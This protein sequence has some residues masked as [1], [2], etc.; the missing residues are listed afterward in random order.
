LLR[1]IHARTG[2]R[3]CDLVCSN[4]EAAVVGV[5]GACDERCNAC[6]RA[7]RGRTRSR[8]GCARARGRCA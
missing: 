7:W 2:R 8:R 6:G 5:R 3:A 1:L 4:L